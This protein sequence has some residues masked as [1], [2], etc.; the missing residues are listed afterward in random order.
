MEGLIK[1]GAIKPLCKLA[2]R[3][4]E[5]AGTNALESLVYLSSHGTSISQCIEDMLDCG[6][7]TRMTDIALSNPDNEIAYPK[8]SSITD[9]WKKRVNFALALL[10]NMTRTE[11]GAVELCGRS[12]PEEAIPSSH[13]EGESNDGDE[14]RQ[15]TSLP[16][17][18]TMALLL[19][20]FMNNSF[21]SE[22]TNKDDDN[23]DDND[24]ESDEKDIE[25]KVQNIETISAKAD[26]PYQH[27]A[28]VL[29]NA[30]QVQQ[31]R[32]FVMR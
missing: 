10:A 8:G 18:P 25:S 31:G 5:I 17:R 9:T 7:I 30:T 28:A 22:S 12:M 26:D 2:S 19:S 13:V 4:N 21:I 6:S 24:N 32:K 14:D 16:S 29:M 3:S 27:F 23:E 15:L 20:R 11:R 1:Y